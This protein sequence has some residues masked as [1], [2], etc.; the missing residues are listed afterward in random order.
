MIQEK[1]KS[2]IRVW[3]VGITAL[4]TTFALATIAFVV[5]AVRQ[6]Y[7]LVSDNYYEQEVQFQKQIDRV[8]RTNILTES[9]KCG[10]S[11][12]KKN[13]EITLPNTAATTGKITLYR[14]SQADL[15]RHYS[16]A[17][18]ADGRQNIPVK[19]LLKGKWK[20]KMLWSA[21]GEEFYKECEIFL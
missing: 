20:M 14:P 19:G 1:K 17:L 21:N 12:D 5:F 9:V 11:N 10:V 8:Q 15:D 3:A 2:T 7:D 6:D 4:Y 18:D 16:L 13:I